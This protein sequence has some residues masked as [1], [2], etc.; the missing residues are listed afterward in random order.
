MNPVFR[1]PQLAQRRFGFIHHHRRTANKGL[2][3]AAEIEQ[4]DGERVQFFAINAPLQQIAVHR[5]LAEQMHHL[6]PLRVAVF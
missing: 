6:Q 3:E 2:V 5:L 1:H 4:P